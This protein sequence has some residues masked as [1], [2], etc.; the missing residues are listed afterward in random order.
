[1]AFKKINRGKTA[2]RDIVKE[3]RATAGTGGQKQNNFAV[4]DDVKRAQRPYRLN[5]V[6]K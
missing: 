1:M 4:S 5:K 2:K 3:A 6:G